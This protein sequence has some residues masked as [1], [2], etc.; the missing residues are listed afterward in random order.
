M[1]KKPIRKF[2]RVGRP[3]KADLA[4][5]S[6]Q[7]KEKSAF[8]A[9]ESPV[10]PVVDQ[11]KATTEAGGLRCQYCKQEF[12]SIKLLAAHV[13]FC[14]DK[15]LVEA[16]AKSAAEK[17]SPVPAAVASLPE[18]SDSPTIP[19]QNIE[20]A[21]ASMGDIAAGHFGEHWR[22]S[23]DE[24]RNL[25]RAW[26]P[27]IELYCPK[28]NHP[29]FAAAGVT[30]LTIGPRVVKHAELRRRS[31]GSSIAGGPVGE[32]KNNGAEE[33]SEGGETGFSL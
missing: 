1:P 11:S 7:Q 18:K 6:Q 19:I 10:L 30:I 3:S 27:I 24:V 28:F 26:K 15:T 21:I 14:A 13:K 32:R 5:K 9:N 17:A 31:K 23:T 2:N 29:I 12:Q 25:A 20:L 4:A 16:R 22:L 8:S 33:I